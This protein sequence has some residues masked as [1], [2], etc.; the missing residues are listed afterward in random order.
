MTTTTAT[1][2]TIVQPAILNVPLRSLVT[3]SMVGAIFGLAAAFIST[4]LLFLG[5]VGQDVTA[6]LM[7]QVAGFP[8]VL[9]PPLAYLL[10]RG[11]Q[12]SQWSVNQFR[13]AAPNWL[14]VALALVI[15]TA[16]CGQIALVIVA[17]S[18]HRDVTWEHYLPVISVTSFGLVFA[19]SFLFR[20]DP[21]LHPSSSCRP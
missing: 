21:K 14:V 19:A 18:M 20:A 12:R 9:A 4:M 3:A 10:T 5:K 7:L 11:E 15:G 1:Q 6:L 16:L 17:F 13:N 8:L 2:A